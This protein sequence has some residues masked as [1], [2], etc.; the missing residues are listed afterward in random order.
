M[1]VCSRDGSVEER[2]ERGTSERSNNC[3]PCN[4][5]DNDTQRSPSNNCQWPGLTSVSEG[6]DPTKKS[7]LKLMG[8]ALLVRCALAHC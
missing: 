6:V 4:D 2:F 7:L 3:V 5:N 1:C 8:L